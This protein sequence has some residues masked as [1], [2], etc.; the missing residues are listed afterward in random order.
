MCVAC[1][2]EAM[3]CRRVPRKTKKAT[4]KFLLDV[5]I[6]WSWRERRRFLRALNAQRRRAGL[7]PVRRQPDGR[8]VL[9]D[10]A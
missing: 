5:P 9:M 4:K 7:P 2:I 6:Q 3:M 8:V 1:D 10:L